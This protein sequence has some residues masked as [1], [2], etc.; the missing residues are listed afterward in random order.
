MGMRAA[1]Q[2][3]IPGKYC[4]FGIIWSLPNLGEDP[5][6]KAYAWIKRLSIGVLL[7]GVAVPVLLTWLTDLASVEAAST[8]LHRLFADWASQAGEHPK[9][10]A[11][12]TLL[13]LG[14]PSSLL[15]L[16]LGGL[17]H[18]GERQ[19]DQRVADELKRLEQ[20]LEQFLLVYDP[21]Y[22]FV[23]RLR[24]LLHRFDEA[25]FFEFQQ[26]IYQ[27]TVEFCG[28]L[29]NGKETFLV[30][31]LEDGKTQV[32]MSIVNEDVRQAV[33][34]NLL[35]VSICQTALHSGTSQVIN[36]TERN[37]RQVMTPSRWIIPGCQSILVC[38][39]P[40][41]TTMR[42]IIGVYHNKVDAF[43]EDND[44]VFLELM[45]D[46]LALA[47]TIRSREVGK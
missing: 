34:E 29:E 31:P 28:T 24:R 36:N 42:G 41:G 23:G 20:L 45:A 6:K 10:A 14:L 44:K 1:P 12:R 18:L 3:P 30:M 7:L 11:W 39:I 27:T 33:A 2:A 25:R 4:L 16:L 37:R 40:V 17:A 22:D 38:P 32:A 5:L 46:L 35:T 15:L 47:Y 43:T 13:I 9:A 26:L 8:W 19:V 21:N